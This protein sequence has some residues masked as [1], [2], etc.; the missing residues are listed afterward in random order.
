[1]RRALDFGDLIMEILLVIIMLIPEKEDTTNESFMCVC[2]YT[3]V[4]LEIFFL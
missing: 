2:V 3:Y 1:M 4:Y